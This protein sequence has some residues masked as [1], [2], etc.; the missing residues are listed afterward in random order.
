[1]AKV[2]RPPQNCK[3][4][5]LEVEFSRR[6]AWYAL[7]LQNL[8]LRRTCEARVGKAATLASYGVENIGLM[9]HECDE[10]RAKG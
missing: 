7:M 1:M 10:E 5:M 9:D 6:W 2:R 3:A 8:V 4:I